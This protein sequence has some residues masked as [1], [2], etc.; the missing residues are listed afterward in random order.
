MT[1][2]ASMTDEELLRT[3]QQ[4][5]AGGSG[6]GAIPPGAKARPDYGAGAYETADGTILRGK[7]IMKGS[8]GPSAEARTRL[9]LGFGP[10]VEAQKNLYAEE[11]W[12]PGEANPTGSNPLSAPRAIVG[13]LLRG[14]KP[15]ALQNVIGKSVGGQR[16]Q[17]YEQ[18]AKSFEAAFMPILSGAA[19]SESE[20]QRLIRAAL[21]EPGDSPAT[22]SRKAKNRA[23]MINGAA[24]LLGQQQPF[25][26]IEAWDFKSK[27]GAGSP[28]PP[29]APGPT[30]KQPAAT[31]G[32]KVISVE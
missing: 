13:N 30:A 17:N 24:K 31:G 12:N 26:R 16:T 5:K 18:A 2:Y 22:L 1:D 8:Q 21:P 9:V 11:Q 27:D 19:V 14:D 25:P 15:N 28:R 20:A 29:G 10:T 6:A 4:A 7:Q 23:M 3:Y 32:W